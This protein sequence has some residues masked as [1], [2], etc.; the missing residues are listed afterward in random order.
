MLQVLQYQLHHM[1]YTLRHV[2]MISY[3]LLITFV[4]GCVPR[5]QQQLEKN[6]S[7]VQQM[8][9]MIDAGRWDSLDTLVTE[10]LQRHSNAT[11]MMPE[12]TSREEFKRFEM[13]LHTSFPDMQVIYEEMVA[14][15]DMVAVYATFTGTNI[16]KLGEISAT[17][18]FVKVKFFAMFRIETGKIAEIWVEWDNISRLI[19][20]G[21]W[22]SSN[23]TEGEQHN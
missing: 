8:G 2:A 20:L 4:I 16:G 9:A 18:R 22:P 13:A 3:L 17:G 23:S 1:E 5:G 12:I 6:K 19:Q 21:L 11:T 7:L 15:G 14:E 10:D